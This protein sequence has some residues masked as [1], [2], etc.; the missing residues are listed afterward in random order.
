[1]KKLPPIKIDFT[2]KNFE[3]HLVEQ[4]DFEENLR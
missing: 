4:L 3:T 2:K 1:M